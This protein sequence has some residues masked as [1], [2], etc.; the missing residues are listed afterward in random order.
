MVAPEGS[1]NTPTAQP[2]LHIQRFYVKEKTFKSPYAPMIFQ[3]EWKPEINIE[4]NI[5]NTNVAEHV[6]EVIVQLNITARNQNRTAFSLEVQQAGTFKI[7]NMSGEPLQ[8]VLAAYC[9]NLLYPYAAKSVA[10]VTVEAGFPALTLTPMNFEGLY[11]QQ[12]Q[13]QATEAPVKATLN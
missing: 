5:K 3:D 8:Q 12:R 9:P 1:V 11:Q 6:Y 10:D 4:M 7:E 2:S 13:Q